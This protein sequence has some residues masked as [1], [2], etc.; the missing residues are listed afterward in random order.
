[1]ILIDKV[2]DVREIGG[3]AHTLFS[4]NVPNTPTLLVVP[5][6]YFSHYMEDSSLAE[7]LQEEL[8]SKLD[9]RAKLCS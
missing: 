7:K 6:S 4:L 2:A 9:S 8:N 1:M 5:A 3:K